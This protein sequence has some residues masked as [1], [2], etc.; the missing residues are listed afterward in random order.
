[1]NEIWFGTYKLR[2]NR[3][4]FD[5]G[6]AN[7]AR[8]EGTGYYMKQPIQDESKRSNR[9]SFAQTARARSLNRTLVIRR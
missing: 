3:A 6:G 8:V 5:K 9:I 1:M 2:A 7:G 4:S